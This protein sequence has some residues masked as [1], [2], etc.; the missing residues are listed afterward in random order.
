MGKSDV[1]RILVVDDEPAVCGF[2]EA[3]ID[4]FGMQPKTVNQSTKVTAEIQKIFYHIVLLD[5]FMPE[6]SG[7][8][9]IEDFKKHSPETKIIIVTGRADTKTAI[10]ALRL[11]AFDFLEKPIDMELLSYTLNRA[12]EVQKTE[13]EFKETRK[14]LE[15]TR[16]RLLTRK[17]NL[18]KAKE[19]LLSAL[20]AKNVV[21]REIKSRKDDAEKRIVINIKSMIIPIIEALQNDSDLAGYKPKLSILISH[22]ENLVAG[23]PTQS[24]IDTSL[25]SSELHIASLI[26]SGLTSQEIAEC[27]FISEST[28][29]T[30]R[31]NLRKKLGI[32]NNQDLRQYLLTLAH[33]TNDEPF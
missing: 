32:G 21:M 31:R 26:M 2:L 29:K 4:S 8:E 11:G 20:E 14:N 25:S 5:V 13:R 18:E 10:Q 9:L 19:T 24:D 16:E 28:V 12:L 33:Q 17:G 15:L 1:A 30:H 6:K 22:L 3:A 7:L 27:T 23:L